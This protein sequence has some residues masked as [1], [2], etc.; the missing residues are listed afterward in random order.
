MLLSYWLIIIVLAALP[1]YY[2]LSRSRQNIFLIAA[3]YLFY[4]SWDYRFLSLIIISTIINF[5]LGSGIFTAKTISVKK[6]FLMTG[7]VFNLGLLGFFKYYGFFIASFISAFQS[8]GF[9]PHV[10]L[11]KLILP[12]GISFFTFKIM[13]YLIDVF[14]GKQAPADFVSFALFVGYFPEMSAGPIGRASAFFPQIDS[15]RTFV[16]ERIF[17]GLQLILIGYVKKMVIAGAIAPSVEQLFSEPQ[18]FRSIDL[19]CGMYLYT[20]QIYADFSGY[21]DI[22]RGISRL[23]GIEIMENFRQPYLSRNIGEF[24]RRWHISLSSWL[25]DYL[26]IPLGGSRKGTVRTYIN[27]LATML[28]CGLWHGA[29]WVFVLWG[30][31]HG[32]YLAVYRFIRD[33]L[34]K[35][36][37]ARQEGRDILKSVLSILVTFHAVGFAWIFF[38]APDLASASSYLSSMADISHFG[39]ASSS[40]LL[41]TLF[42]VLLTLAVDLPLYRNNR[43]LLVTSETPWPWRGIVYAL[44]I[45]SISFLGESHVQPFI[46]FQF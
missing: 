43:E 36:D 29:S 6:S 30:G 27:L 10:P 19:L 8:L 5:Y 32:I 20:I 44:L 22:V 1:V 17:A 34:R 42:Y 28:L 39:Y 16:K 33:S 35:T 38:R 21:T 45:L 37:S 41:I 31:I 25:R 7:L 46:Y 18:Q 13:G 4:C 11:L 3:S 26:Y 23:L 24:W 2:S 9:V 12:L 40:L 15:R 14:R